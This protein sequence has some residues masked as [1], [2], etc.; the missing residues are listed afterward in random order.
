MDSLNGVKQEELL[1][2]EASFESFRD[3]QLALSDA[4]QQHQEA[5]ERFAEELEA[6]VGFTV[7]VQGI[8]ISR[9]IYQPSDL[10][11]RSRFVSVRV[12]PLLE[13]GRP[14][15]VSYENMTILGISDTRTA[16]HVT[17]EYMEEGRG[18][19]TMPLD[20]IVALEVTEPL[21]A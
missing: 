10:P 21:E 12:T 9:T 1:S 11:G 5:Q 18:Y 17:N 19:F 8:P 15:T 3:S 7:N 4:W 16:L 14:K 20:S 6:R 13:E 2:V